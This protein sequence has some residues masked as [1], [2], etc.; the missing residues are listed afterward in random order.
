MS[1][2]D[3]VLSDE[4]IGLDGASSI[5]WQAICGTSVIDWVKT[6]IAII[7]A[8][9]TSSS[10]TPAS[11]AFKL[12]WRNLTDAGSFVDL[13]TSGELQRG[14][15]A[16]AITNGDAVGGGA[17]CESVIDDSEEVEN[18]SPLLTASLTGTQNDHIETQWAVDFSNALALKEYEF[19]LWSDTEGASTGTLTATITVASAIIELVG[20]LAATSNTP[21]PN[22]EMSMKLGAQD[23]PGVS[24]LT[25][26]LLSLNTPL[27]IATPIFG[28]S[29][30]L[31]TILLNTKILSAQDITGQS[32][33]MTNI[34]LEVTSMVALIGSLDAQSDVVTA[35][36]KNSMKLGAQDI[37]GQ[38]DLPT[39]VLSLSVK[40]IG[41]SDGQS[42]LEN[43]LLSLLTK[44]VGSLVGQAGLDGVITFITFKLEGITVDAGGDPL[45][46]CT[47]RLYLTSSDLYEES[48]VSN[49]VTGAYIF[50]GIEDNNQRYIIAYKVGT[51]VFG[52]TDDLTP[53]EE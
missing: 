20:S 1:G 4:R 15:S 32:G 42:S 25:N 37:V 18:E 28:V 38:S 39:N 41:T 12:Q 23:I 6:N 46:S 33:G 8:F 9:C 22:I 31:T 26:L 14:V 27:S 24:D 40:I 29:N 50:T 17:G 34:P 13:T 44:L 19:R 35:L 47:V 52:T 3:Y 5:T 48:V 16:G 51:P 7:A 36:L 43:N 49:A 21:A 53:V 45:G 10:H 2:S 11:E 30:V